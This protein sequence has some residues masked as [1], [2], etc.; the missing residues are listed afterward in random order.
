[1]AVLSRR[2][3]AEQIEITLIQEQLTYRGK[4]RG[5][6]IKGRQQHYS[7]F[8]Y[9]PRAS[10]LVRGVRATH[11]VES[12][13]R[14]LV[15]IRLG[16]TLDERKEEIVA[17]SA[18]MPYDSPGPTPSEESARLVEDYRRNGRGTHHQMR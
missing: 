18:Y 14:D 5:L 15:A 16:I 2:I 9:R 11:L 17:A 12:S 8:V 6:N 13:R 3:V 7:T 10:T 4:L 1:M